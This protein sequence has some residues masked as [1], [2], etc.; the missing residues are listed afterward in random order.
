MAF[1]IEEKILRLEITVGDAL[2]MQ[3]RHSTKNLL[4]AAFNFARGHSTLFYRSVEIPTRTELH[5]LAPFLTL[6][7]DKIDSLDDIDMM[8]GRRDAK[9][10][11][12]FLDVLFLRLVLATFAEFLD[13]NM[14][15]EK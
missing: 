10:G 3:V 8:K 5:H 1:R 4:E 2:T 11:G 6:V 14:S 15:Q 12:E 13:I 9:L 7:L